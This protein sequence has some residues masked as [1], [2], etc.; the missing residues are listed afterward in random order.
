MPATLPSNVCTDTLDTGEQV[1]K[2]FHP[3]KFEIIE[4]LS[5]NTAALRV[6]PEMLFADPGEPNAGP[7]THQRLFRLHDHAVACVFEQ[8]REFPY[9]RVVIHAAEKLQGKQSIDETTKDGFAYG[10][11]GSWV[12]D[13]HANPD[14][15]TE[16]IVVEAMSRLG[17]YPL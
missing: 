13:G 8:G 4:W 2:E 16:Q 5:A 14:L 6:C 7:S 12:Q 9:G 3:L 10:G 17:Y 15:T 11:F 1:L